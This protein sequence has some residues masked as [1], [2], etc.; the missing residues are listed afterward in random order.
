M[1]KEK[2]QL[3]FISDK[4]MGCIP[5]PHYDLCTLEKAP[6]NIGCLLLEKEAAALIGKWIK[7][8]NKGIK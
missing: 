2:L 4:H 8:H 1:Y 3:I 5:H 6:K 7:Q